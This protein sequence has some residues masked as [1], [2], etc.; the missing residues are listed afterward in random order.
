MRKNRI[1]ATYNCLYKIPHFLHSICPCCFLNGGGRYEFKTV[2][3][4]IMKPIDYV[5][6]GVLVLA[7]TLVIIHLIKR[8]KEGKGGCGCGCASCPSAGS[9]MAAQKNI[10]E[11]ENK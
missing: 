4:E 7:V 1:Q 8:K 10:K 5:I 9:C 6:I 2:L 3:G 11:E